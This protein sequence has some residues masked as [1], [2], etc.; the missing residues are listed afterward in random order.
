MPRFATDPHWLIYLPPTLPLSETSSRTGYLEYP[1][2][3]FNYFR[4]NGVERVVCQEKHL[5]SL[6]RWRVIARDTA[7]ARPRTFRRCRR[8]SRG[9]VELAGRS[10][11][12]SG[13]AMVGRTHRRGR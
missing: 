10:A 9:E 4:R 3:S 1:T 5:G 8:A 12:G 2:E 13:L 7:A 6:G 11:S